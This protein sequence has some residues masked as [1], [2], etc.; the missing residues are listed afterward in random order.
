MLCSRGEK[1]R[2]AT[3]DRHSNCDMPVSS[4][5]EL[6]FK[7]GSTLRGVEKGSSNVAIAEI[8]YM[9]G[10]GPSSILIRSRLETNPLGDH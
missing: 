2:K 10:L 9:P 5:I 8:T 3:R 4:Y 1:K 6:K 7:A